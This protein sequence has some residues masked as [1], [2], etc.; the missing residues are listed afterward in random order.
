MCSHTVVAV[1]A[2]DPELD[3]LAGEIAWLLGESPE[4][5]LLCEW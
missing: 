4:T 5:E 3:T 2:G 1:V